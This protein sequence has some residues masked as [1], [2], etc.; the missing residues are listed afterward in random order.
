MTANI[1]Q[2]VVAR[3]RGSPAYVPGLAWRQA[4]SAGHVDHGTITLGLGLVGL[5]LV[6]LLAFFYLQ[7][8]LQT[9]E[10]GSDIH[11]MEIQ[12]LELKEKQR[13]LELEGAQL[14]SLQTVE[15]RLEKLNLVQTGQVSY[16][17]I[18]LPHVALGA[19]L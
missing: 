16:L 17:N 5:L 13:A 4:A 2:Y 14:R 9:A 15:G 1:R 10:S 6:S 7:Q 12:L 3:R 19:S 11:A 8:V 18:K